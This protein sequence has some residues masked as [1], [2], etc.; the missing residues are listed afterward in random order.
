MTVSRQQLFDIGMLVVG[1][2]VTAVGRSSILLLLLSLLLSLW[3]L[4]LSLGKAEY[5]PRSTLSLTAPLV[6]TVQPM[7]LMITM[8]D[9]CCTTT[10]RSTTEHRT[11]QDNAL[12]W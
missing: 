11:Y 12:I 9:V 8:Y 5:N 2:F 10:C 4:L 3:S 6:L 1:G 7:M